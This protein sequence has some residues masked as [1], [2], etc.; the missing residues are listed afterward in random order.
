MFFFTPFQVHE[1]YGLFTNLDTTIHQ[2]LQTYISI[3]W[4]SHFSSIVIAEGRLKRY[5]R[6]YSSCVIMNSKYTIN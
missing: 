3:V 1:L 4:V 6:I 5:S 2:N